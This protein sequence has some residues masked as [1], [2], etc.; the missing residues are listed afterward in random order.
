MKT[1]LFLFLIIQ[2]TIVVS[3]G[4]IASVKADANACELNSLHL[5]GLRNE[6]ANNPTAKIIAKFYAGK[7]ENNIVS[8]KRTDYIRKFLEKHKGFDSSRLEFINSGKLKTNENPKTEF[9]ILQAGET[10]GTL[11]LVTY[12]RP[13]RTPCLDCCGEDLLPKNIGSKPK[14]KQKTIKKPKK[15]GK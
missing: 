3:L 11:Y 5:D 8:E 6:L 15:R 4:Q 14:P 1:L 13:N 10:E 9:Y 7:S 12:S 2:L